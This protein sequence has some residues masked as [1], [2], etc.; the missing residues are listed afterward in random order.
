MIKELLQSASHPREIS[1]M[2]K[3]KFFGYGQ[4]KVNEPLDELALIVNDI[5]FCYAALNKVSR[6]FAMVIR[7]LPEELRDPVCIF[8]LVLR[9]LDTIEDD[10][11]FQDGYKLPLLRNFY[12]KNYDDNWSINGVGDTPDYRALLSHYYKVSRSF[13]KLDKKYQAIIID[14]CRQMGEGMADYIEKEVDTLSDYD[15][16]CHYVAGLVGVGLNRLFVESG[17]ESQALAANEDLAN[18]MGLFL[19]KTN[20]TRDYYEDLHFDRSFWPKQIWSKYTSDLSKLERSSNSNSSLFCLNH[21]VCDA[22]QHAS[23]SLDYLSKISDK[24]VFRFCAIPQ[25]MAIA[26]LAEVYNNPK[27]FTSTVKIRKGLTARLVLKINDFETTEHYFKF[28]AKELLSKVVPGDP[29][30]DL[31]NERLY[32]IVNRTVNEPAY[33]A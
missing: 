3:M 8:Y 25:V 4:V 6:S 2:V 31:I 24:D 9:G 12:S 28:F 21:M 10:S 30:F 15:Q 19:Q 18:A 26:T 17:I 7:Q 29:N 27:V 5:E 33:I 32:Q 23:D 14:I 20:I 11:S 1:A 13:Q 16:Y 22:L